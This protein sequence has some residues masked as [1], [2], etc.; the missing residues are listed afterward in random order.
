[1]KREP[2]G[3]ENHGRAV[4]S[5]LPFSSL[6]VILNRTLFR[7]IGEKEGAQDMKAT[8]LIDNIARDNLKQ[9]WGLS[10]LIEFGDKT[11]LLDTGASPAFLENALK[12][13]KEINGVD[14]GVLSHAH[15]DHSDGMQAFFEKNKKAAFYIREGSGENCYGRWFVFNK[16]IGIQKGILE[17]YADRIRY[18]KGNFRLSEGVFLIPHSTSGL[19][20]TGKKN[21]MYVKKNRKWYADDFSHEQ[22]LVFDTPK[23]LVI[24]NSCSHA[25]AGNIIREVQAAFPEKQLLAMIGGFHLYNVAEEEVRALAADMKSTGIRKVYTGHCTGNKAYRILKEELGEGLSQLETGKVI[26]L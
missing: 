16:Y 1:M 19:S 25:G 8:I 22:S 6:D 11:I 3:D 21:H 12:L 13:G 17:Q 4:P 2:S 9:E 24:F 26:E 7:S 10:I 5:V 18:A 14:Y 15:Y 20:E 23:G